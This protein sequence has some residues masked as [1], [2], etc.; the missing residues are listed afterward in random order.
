MPHISP[1]HV[2]EKVL[3]EISSLLFSAIADKYISPKQQRVAFNEIFTT[4]EKVMLGKRLAAV[5]LLSDGMSPYEVG[6]RLRLS[7]TTTAKFHLKLEKGAF[8]G[9][10]KLCKILR[11]GVLGRYLDNLLRPLPRYG[12]S[13][14]RLFRDK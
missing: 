11:K 3:K 9:T 6:K 1:R 4:T 10:E 5:S 8:S 7:P 12:T 13:P 2:D 14:H